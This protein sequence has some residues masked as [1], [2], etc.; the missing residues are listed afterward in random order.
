MSSLLNI[1]QYYC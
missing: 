1:K